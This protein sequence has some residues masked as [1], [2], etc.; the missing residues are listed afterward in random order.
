MC[1]SV[2]SEHFKISFNFSFWIKQTFKCKGLAKKKRIYVICTYFVQ[3]CIE[4][5]EP[6]VGRNYTM[7]RM[8][9]LILGLDVQS[10][11]AISLEDRI[12]LTEISESSVWVYNADHRISFCDRTLYNSY[13][14]FFRSLS[15]ERASFEVILI[16][17]P[18]LKWWMHRFMSIVSYLCFTL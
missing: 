10:A 2:S 7:E 18:L 9:L 16:L 3:E 5:G 6:F 8:G 15:R 14:I 17:S 1:L 4:C 11:T 13:N 12:N